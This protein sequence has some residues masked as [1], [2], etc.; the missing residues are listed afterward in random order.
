MVSDMCDRIASGAVCSGL[1][2]GCEDLATFT[3][4]LKQGYAIPQAIGHDTCREV[5]NATVR[6]WLIWLLRL[7]MLAPIMLCACVCVRACVRA[8]ACMCAYVQTTT[9]GGGGGGGGGGGRHCCQLV[10]LLSACAIV[11]WCAWSLPATDSAPQHNPRFD[12][13]ALLSNALLTRAIS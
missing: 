4:A 1:L 5:R 13:A 11:V 6:P 3:R 8:C 2:A 12:D 9:R 10:T 7:R